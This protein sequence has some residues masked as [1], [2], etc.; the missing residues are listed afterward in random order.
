MKSPP[1]TCLATVDRPPCVIRAIRLVEP[2]QLL[3]LLLGFIGV[4]RIL[5]AKGIQRMIRIIRVTVRTI[6]AGRTLSL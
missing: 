1:H 3:A 6:R 4:V 5:L 2:S